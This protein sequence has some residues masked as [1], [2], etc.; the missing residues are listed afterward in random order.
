MIDLVICIVHHSNEKLLEELIESIESSKKK[1]SYEIAILDNNT[2]T[3]FI[4]FLKNKFNNIQTNF[5]NRI[6]GYA[7]NQNLLLKDNYKSS[8]F[9][10]VIN[11]DTFFQDEHSLQILFNFMVENSNVAAASPQI[12][13]KDYTPQPVYGPIGTYL[14]HTLRLCRISK[15]T[16][17]RLINFLNKSKLKKILPKFIQS[18][19]S[20]H[21]NNSTDTIVD[22]VSGCCMIINN[23]Y[24][25]KIGFFDDDNFDM[26]CDDTDWCLRA[27]KLNYKLYKVGNSKIIHYGG[28]SVYP[29]MVLRKEITIL[30]YLKKHYPNSFFFRLYLMTLMVH[31]II[32]SIYNLIKLFGDRKYIKYSYEYFKLIFFSFYYF[33]FNIKVK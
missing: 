17:K 25:N 4:N 7:Y 2:K 22:K 33:L 24:I 8:K 5:S 6:K 18:Y 11:D 31:S 29:G 26:Y 32:Q 9:S 15:I 28:E 13:N 20:A 30:K 3:N 14:S 12:L 1:F 21:V 19:F 27:A 16:S 10:L 23:K